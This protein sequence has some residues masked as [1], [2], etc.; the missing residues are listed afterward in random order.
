MTS[1][2][3]LATR[4]EMYDWGVRAYRA[5]RQFSSPERVRMRGTVRRWIRSCPTRAVVLDVGGG[6]SALR[7]LI[8]RE[9]DE[10]YYLSGDIAPTSASSLVMDALAMPLRE[11]SVDAVIALEVLEHIPTPRG[12]LTEVARVLRLNGILILTTPFM[13]GVHDFRDYFRFTPRGLE[14]LLTGSGL[15]LTEVELRGGT[16]TAAA[17]LFRTFA[18][19]SIVGDPQDWRANDRAKK[20]RW[21]FATLIMLPWVPVMWTAATLDR[22]LDPHSKN[23]PGYFFLCRKTG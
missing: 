4:S 19:N 8:E 9:V 11:S 2:L 6:V 23:P 12:M 17:G 18:V 10:V 21:V 14:Q 7:A 22:I 5:Y 16:F 1:M 3:R 20:L 15:E 13:F